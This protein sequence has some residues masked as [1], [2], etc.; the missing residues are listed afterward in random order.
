MGQIDEVARVVLW[1]CGEGA[2]FT[3]GAVIPIDGGQGAGSKPPQMY[4]QG[5]GIRP[6]S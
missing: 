5:E 1:L 4:R 6:T 2:S 3:T